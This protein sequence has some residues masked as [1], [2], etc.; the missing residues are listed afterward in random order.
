MAIRTLLSFLFSS[1]FVLM[2][3]GCFNLGGGTR[4]MTRFFVLQ[5][6]SQVKKPDINF[7]GVKPFTLGIGPV[8]IPK[9]L[10]RRHVVLRINDTEVQLANFSRWAEPLSDNVSRV[11]SEN[12][13][14]LLGTDQVVGYPWFNH[15]PDYQIKIDIMQFDSPLKGEAILSARWQVIATQEKKEILRTH[16]VFKESIDVS[17]VEAMIPVMGHLLE[18]FSR[19]IAATMVEIL[20]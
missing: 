18:R 5:A 17:D 10:D 3:S 20:K 14:F 2:V 6:L 7:D 15:S 12:L 16:S 8:S 1:M 11:F 13:S 19:Q 9:L 4:D